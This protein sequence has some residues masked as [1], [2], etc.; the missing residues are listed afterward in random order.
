MAKKLVTFNGKTIAGPNGA[1]GMLTTYEMPPCADMTLRFAFSQPGYNPTG[2]T[3]KGTWTQVEH[4]YMN[5]WDW[6]C[7]DT[8]WATA[9]GGGGI[10]KPGKFADYEHN[11]VMV[12]DSGDTSVVTDFSR[13]FQNCYAITSICPI[14]TRTATTVYCMF[15]HCENCENFPDM[16]LSNISESQ[17]TIGT[18]QSCY[19]MKIAPNILFPTDK[20][21][22]LQNFFSNSHSLEAVPL[23][24][25]QKCKVMENMFTDT[26]LKSIPLFDLSSITNM[27]WAFSY[28]NELISAESIAE[29]DLSNITD[30]EGIFMCCENLRNVSRFIF[31]TPCSMNRLFDT[32]YEGGQEWHKSSLETVPNWD[33]SK[34]TS[35][36]KAFRGCKKLTSIPAMNIGSTTT[37]V[38][39]IFEECTNIETGI[40][41]LYNT[42]SQL[43]SITEH[44]DAFKN[45]GIDTL[46]GHYQLSQIPTSWGGL[47]DPDHTVTIGGRT[48]RTVTIGNQEWMAENL[49]LDVQGSTW[50][51]ND[52]SYKDKGYG[53]IYTREQALSV[54]LPDG[55]RL[56]TRND[57]SKLENTI[58]NVNKLLAK[59]E[60][61]NPGTDDYG[62]FAFPTTILYD[63]KTEIFVEDET[64]ETI[65]IQDTGILHT[66]ASYA[67]SVRFVK[68]LT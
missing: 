13:F 2:V 38:D 11:K 21:F 24:N 43:S 66:W 58:Q 33:W 8:S 48:Y 65:L 64:D 53:K 68:D 46:E 5:V 16:I 63:K 60:W 44:T 20:L 56:P 39:H 9:F 17:G 61:N 14:D 22:T 12:I 57:F 51:N 36:T 27:R 18:Y 23:Y 49:E 3:S 41:P 31:N 59:I 7:T 32:L 54:T 42:L 52:S 47:L 10:G 28:C 45:C 62:F 67:G 25:M 35:L 15:S 26:K 4:P 30:I 37:K 6:T 50:Y 34:A 19:K 1:A 29:L 55:W 40:L